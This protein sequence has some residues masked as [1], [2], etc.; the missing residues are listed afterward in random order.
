[1]L[2]EQY[3]P[4]RVSECFFD[5]GD[6]IEIINHMGH[7]K[8]KK[9]GRTI[10]NMLNGKNTIRTIVDCLCYELRRPLWKSSEIDIYSN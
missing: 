7:I 10:W 4:C 3:T 1:M 5:S 8:L 6:E 2:I 9:S